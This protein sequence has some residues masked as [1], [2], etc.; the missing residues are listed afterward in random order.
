[1]DGMDR[2]IED[3]N[4]TAVVKKYCE[5]D[6]KDY[7]R[8]L[9]K[10]VENL[11]G[12][13]FTKCEKLEEAQLQIVMQEK[14]L[15]LGNLAAGIA[16]EINNPAGVVQGA[17]DTLLRSLKK[18]QNVFSDG[19]CISDKEKR[20]CLKK[21]LKILH[22]NSD[23]VVKSSKR[24]TRVIKSLKNFARLDEASYKIVDIHEGIENSISL[25]PGELLKNVKIKR[26]YGDI[27]RIGC[28][29]NELNQA[30]MNILINAAQAIE[31]D[32][33][34]IIK[35]F[36]ED[37]HVMIKISDTGKGIDP[38]NVNKIFNPGY[39]TKGTGVG[40]GLGLSICY[41]IVKKHGGDIKVKSVPGK[42]TSVILSL[43]VT[44]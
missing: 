25:L 18:L 38:E 5:L 9:E 19:Y 27:I 36:M 22:K 8:S 24:I 31:N 39:T 35:T 2:N 20:N 6:I 1:M 10:R 26:K 11:S 4:S 33:K 3:L 14:M 29:P 17:T 30:L 7:V 40:T 34:I 12:Q 44:Q 41:R 42:G 15:S 43:P 37:K 23:A 21:I 32:G 16:H 13:M 28:Y